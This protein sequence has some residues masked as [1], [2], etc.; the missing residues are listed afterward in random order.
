MQWIKKLTTKAIGDSTEAFAAQHLK[1]QGLVF[2]EQNF[3]SKFG[4]IDLIFQEAGTLIFV[5][6]KYRKSASYGGAVATVSA[7]KQQKLKLCASFYLQQSGLNEYNTP[8]RF[9]VVA[10]QGDIDQPQ[11]TWLKNAF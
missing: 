1:A 10:L 8:C 3:S 9:D 4:E 2:V 5:E 7:S 11:I 6:V